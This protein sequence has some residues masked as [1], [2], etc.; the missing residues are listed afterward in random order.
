MRRLKKKSLRRK[1]IIF[2]VQLKTT[3][4]SKNYFTKKNIFNKERKKDQKRKIRK[5]KI[6]DNNDKNA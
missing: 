1:V 4:S 5:A 3:N 6:N 2:L